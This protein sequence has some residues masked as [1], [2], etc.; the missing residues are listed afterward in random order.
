MKYRI[1]F[2][3]CLTA[4]AASLFFTSCI[5]ETEPPSA[6]EQLDAELRGIDQAKLES[7]LKIIDDTL[8]RR[9]LTAEAEKEP[10]G[11]RYIVHTQGTGPK[12]TLNS[13]LKFKYTGKLLSTGKVFDSGTTT[14][15]VALSLLIVGWR[16]TLPLLNE[17]ADVTLYIPSQLGYKAQPRTDAAGNIV[18]P[19]NSNL[20]F[21]IELLDVL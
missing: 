4:I 10:H 15:P 11:V 6:Q 5:K 1:V 8:Q 9:Q 2:N 18:I 19:A 17:G 12:P 14:D 20:E 21:R 13:S 16:T 3:V 7:D